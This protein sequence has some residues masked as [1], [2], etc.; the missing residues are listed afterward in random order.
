MITRTFGTHL[1]F[2]LLFAAASMARADVPPDN[3]LPIHIGADNRGGSRFVGEIACAR[4]YSRALRP[5]EVQ[6]LARLRPGARSHVAALT[7]EWIFDS[8]DGQNFPNRAGAG[9]EAR[10]VGSVPVVSID[11]IRAARFGDGYLEVQPDSRLNAKRGMTLEAWV[12]PGELPDAGGRILDRISVGGSDGWLLD[13]YP[14]ASPRLIV[15]AEQSATKAR[16]ASGTWVHLAAT[17]APDGTGRIYMNGRDMKQFRASD[18]VDYRGSAPAPAGPL[19]LW[20]RHPAA[21]WTEALPLGNGRLGAMVYGGVRRER[22]LLND[23][24]LWSGEPADTLPKEAR[25]ALPEVRR[26][27][28]A[29][30]NREAHDLVARKMLG[31]F[32][33]CYLPM[34]ELD[35]DFGEAA[36][37]EGYRRDL[38]LSE[39]VTRVRYR[40]GD[41]TYTREAF[42]SHPDRAIVLRLACDQPGRL[43]FTVGLSSPL[44]FKTQ[45][46]GSTVVLT[47]RCPKFLDAYTG[48]PTE[49]D[50]SP[51]GQGMRFDVRARLVA[52]GGEVRTEGDRLRVRDADSVLLVLAAATSYNGFDKSPSREGKDP[53]AACRGDLEALNGRRFEEIRAAHVADYRRLFDRVHL[54]LGRGPNAALPTDE[55]VAQYAQERDPGLAALYFQFGRY[56]L[57]GGSRD[58]QPLN[59]QGMWCSQLPA[60]WASNWTLNCNAEIDYWPVEVVNLSEC[61]LP[62]INLTRELAVDGARVAREMYGARG[63]MAHHN[64]DIWKRATPVDGDPLWAS[65]QTGGAWLCRHLWEHYAFTGDVDYL[66]SVWPVMR[67]AA[68]YFLESMLEEPKHGWLVTAPATNFESYFRKPDG[69]TAAICM[70]PTGDM[71]I[72]RELFTDCLKAGKILDVD[73]DFRA[74]IEKALPRLAPMQVSPRTGELQEWCEDW[75]HANPGNG[76]MLSLWGLICGSQITPKG[77]PVLAKAIRKSLDDRKPWT[78]WVGSWTGAF[79]SNAFAR[80][81]DGDMAESVLDK[82]LGKVVN[83]NLTANFEGMSEWQIDGNMGQTAAVAEMLLQSRTGDVHLLPALPR[84]WRQGSVRG[85]RARGGFEVD[86]AWRNGALTKAMVRSLLGN[87]CTV[88]YGERTVAVPTEKGHEYDFDALLRMSKR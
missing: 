72:V 21:A 36:A 46:T 86:I 12:R 17:I 68:R 5:T 26:L 15:G 60:P 44:H 83:P 57:I 55:R 75:D 59:L 8:V 87:A 10:V 31:P 24:T 56:L 30:K 67:E 32:F 4:L 39:G 66:R 22:I 88:R 34:G 65:F 33:Q 13:T 11:G 62:L 3:K 7:A 9:L 48:K 16:L 19:T 45:A 37:V 41:A 18:G 25:A 52:E 82:H 54:D 38:D 53:A 64:A 76:Q 27:L 2:V 84:R 47:G 43:N 80:L 77:T 85:L 73:S 79:S 6:G 14:G 40:I 35:L 63:W 78:T 20:Y 42:A 74:E 49:Y 58:S 28:L 71:Q 50:D 61:H 23:D 29:G 70:G 69:E 1:L 51:D 81:E